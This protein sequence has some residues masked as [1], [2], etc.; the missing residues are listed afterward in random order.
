MMIARFFQMS[1]PGLRLRSV[2]IASLIGF[3]SLLSGCQ[4]F[5]DTQAPKS[6]TVAGRVTYADNPSRGMPGVLVRAVGKDAVA[7]TDSTGWFLL[8]PSVSNGEFLQLSLTKPG[9]NEVVTTLTVQAG[10]A[11]ALSSPI[12]LTSTG[13]AGG[14]T[15]G[16]AN[17]VV[18]KSV[19]A[20]SIGVDH[21]GTNP[22][23]L[24]TF[25]VRDAQ[26]IPVNY[27][28][29][30]TVQFLLSQAAGGG[31]FLNPDTASTDEAGL[32]A[33]SL[34][35]GTLAQS[36]QVRAQVMGT[37]IYSDIV[38]VAIHGGLPDAKHFSFAV[39][40][41]NI[42]GLYLLG[43][44]DPVTAFVGDRYGNPVPVGTMVYFTSGA[45]IIEGSAA[46]DD[47]GRATVD[48]ESAA[49]LPAATPV[50]SDSA[51]LVRISA[52][53]VD[54]NRLP[55]VTS[56]LAVMFTGQSQLRVA[57]TTF[58][59]PLG[60]AQEFTVTLDD[61]EHHNPLAAGTTISVSATQGTLGGETSVTLPDTW[62]PAY[63]SFTFRLENPAAG[64]ALI[65]PSHAIVRLRP[66]PWAGGDRTRVEVASG[67]ASLSA[68]PTS[69]LA[70]QAATLTITVTSPNGGAHTVLSGVLE[71]P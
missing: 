61:A 36:V 14:G 58:D 32:V 52:Q 33:V 56:A 65:G 5:T 51:G 23:S 63:T 69:V 19:S 3:G 4:H 27:S 18:L 60:G 9:Y 55:I 17:S 41:L 28:H 22:T 16:A 7:T 39:K 57:P 10:V 40:T 11:N 20:P 53:T 62:D 31:A 13:V 70:S 25:E 43:T 29:R 44:I 35:A 67:G 30:A 54:Q 12:T 47:H 48:L 34:N 46:T 1:S 49:P 68:A 45:G 59:I 24:L 50:T 21:A 64:P 26:G 38:P 2:L 37:G 71:R 8:T 6:T 66:M 42:P 15:G